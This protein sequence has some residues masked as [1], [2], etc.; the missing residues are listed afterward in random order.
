MHSIR[1]I[2]MYQ[3][4]QSFLDDWK[5]ESGK[6]LQILEAMTNASLTQRVSE[7]GRTAGT[8]AW[9]MV[10]ALSDMMRRFDLTREGP[11]EDDPEPTTAAG[12]VAGYKTITASFETQA[13]AV[14]T[15]ASL[16][17][18]RELY[19]E[20]WSIEKTLNILIRHEIHHRAQLTV[21]LRQAGLRIPGVYGPAYE[22]WSDLGMEPLP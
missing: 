9:H 7:N 21:L 3:T 11:A 18:V 6:T 20:P 13:T 5:N 14:W 22:E 1:G 19:G 8:L 12:I 2:I 4:L 16:A 10:N 15:D 17:E